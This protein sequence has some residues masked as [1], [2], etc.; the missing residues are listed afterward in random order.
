MDAIASLPPF[1]RVTGPR[2]VENLDPYLVHGPDRCPDS[3]ITLS[4][5]LD[6]KLGVVHETGEVREIE[7]ENLSPDRDLFILAGE[8]VKGGRQ[9]RT[10]G[11]D[12]VVPA[13]SPRAKVPAF[14]VERRRWARRGAEE[15]LMKV[16][17][18]KC[19]MH[20]WE[21]VD[22]AQD[23]LSNS[24]GANV[25]S[26]ASPGSYQLMME[27][28][29][30]RSRQALLHQELGA[31]MES[32]RDVIGFAFV[33]NGRPS[34]AD[35]FASSRL[36]R[37][38][39]RKLLDAPIVI[40]L[41]EVDRGRSANDE[42]PE[43]GADDVS[44]WLAAALDQRPSDVMDVPPRLRVEQGDYHAPRRTAFFA[45]HDH[46]HGVCLHRSWTTL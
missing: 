34:T 12:L 4:E 13:R 39:S 42:G 29:C 32:Q 17:W 26:M 15:L 14:C 37:S 23:S 25:T 20:V 31:W 40:A 38:F 21:A 1:D 33:I 27:V 2:R 43:L 11:M 9:D 6:A 44:L 24:L 30:V 5:A 35:L 19:Q 28:D 16:K 10:L 18:E 41:V 7:I 45:S 36:A 3:F 8:V 22:A 46:G